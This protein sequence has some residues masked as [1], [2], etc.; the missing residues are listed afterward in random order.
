M[1]VLSKVMILAE[2]RPI[3]GEKKNLSDE[4]VEQLE[5]RTVRV[6]L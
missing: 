3:L 5:V 1:G 2:V 4:N 6:G